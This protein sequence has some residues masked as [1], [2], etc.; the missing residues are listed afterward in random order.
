MVTMFVIGIVVALVIEELTGLTPGGLIVPGFLAL[1][2]AEP[3]RLA[4]TI[5]AALVTGLIVMSIQGRMLLYGRRRFGYSVLTG[6]V[7]KGALVWLLPMLKMVPYGLLVIGMVIPGLIAET[8]LRQGV[9]KTL[10]AMVVAVA[11]TR[12]ASLAVLGWLP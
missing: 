3:L 10:A 2:A 5:A 12:M 11:L 6:I 9:M 4:A 7:V 8:F 1:H